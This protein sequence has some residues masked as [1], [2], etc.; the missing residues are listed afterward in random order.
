MK[1]ILNFLLVLLTCIPVSAQYG[2]SNSLFRQALV[3]YQLGGK[4]YFY[5]GTEQQLSTVDNIR[6]QYAY[7]KDAHILYVITDNANVAITL[8]KDYAKI[9]KKNKSIPQL[10]GEELNRI[11]AIYTKQL[12]DRYSL[13]NEQR[14]KF[15]ED[16]IL[17]VKA[18]SIELVRRHEQELAQRNKREQY[19]K[20]HEFQWVPIENVTLECPLC[21]KSFTMDSVYCLGI[22]NDSIYY[23]TT[24]TKDFDVSQTSAHVSKIPNEL[25]SKAKFIYH[26]EVFKDSLTNDTVDFASLVDYVNWKYN[27]EYLSKLRRIA[28][29]GYFDDWGWDDKYSMLTFYFN[30]VNTN[31]KTIRYITVYFKITN[32]VGDVRNIGYFKGT[33][34]LKQW[35]S[36][37]WSWDSSDYFL[38]GDASSMN[39]TKVVLTWMN[40]KTQVVTGKYLQFNTSNE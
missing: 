35:E 11:I 32:D 38:Y 30:Y 8:N 6:E 19:R 21:E 14:R 17:K 2:N 31:P 20:T 39:I 27:N 4:G 26:Y 15:I 10:K 33:G 1:R 34:P 28:P 37:N 16:S 7:D 36:A 25:S 18:D 24:E 22:K 3:I 40:G 23:L 12:D 9:I 13:Q 5:R 29:F